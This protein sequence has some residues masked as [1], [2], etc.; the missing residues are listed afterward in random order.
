MQLLSTRSLAVVGKPMIVFGHWFGT[1]AGV[2]G[3]A[4]SCWTSLYQG[5]QTIQM[6][7][8]GPNMSTNSPILLTF[9]SLNCYKI[10]IP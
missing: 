9:S 1:L 4:G 3:M 2:A 6:V 5:N 7:G 8:Q 10:Q